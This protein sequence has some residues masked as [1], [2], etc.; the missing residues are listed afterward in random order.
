MGFMS[1]VVG[2]VIGFGMQCSCNAA[3]KVPISRK[4]WLHLL[5]FGIGCYLGDKYPKVEASL[6]SELNEIRA[7]RGMP[8]L[9]PSSKW[10]G[11]EPAN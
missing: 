6:L 10:L 4:P 8:P 2:G 11:V 5:Y 1:G 7:E 3:V 9:I